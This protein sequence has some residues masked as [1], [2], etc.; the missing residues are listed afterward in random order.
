MCFYPTVKEDEILHVAKD[1]IKVFKIVKSS[2]YD[3]SLFSYY[4]NYVYTV[5]NCYESRL[6]TKKSWFRRRLKR[7][8]NGIHS[9][10]SEFCEGLAW[11]Y[12]DRNL[13]CSCRT[14][15]YKYSGCTISG[16]TGYIECYTSREVPLVRM[17]CVIPAGARYY[18]NFR[19]EMV[20][21]KLR[22]VAMKP[23]G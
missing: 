15:R 10:S 19:G 9:Y 16:R 18:E 21:D 11:W 14:P 22:V 6:G 20:S 8:E 12:D 7:V 4:M 23:L 2:G 17:D 1:D 13:C 5:G 3:C